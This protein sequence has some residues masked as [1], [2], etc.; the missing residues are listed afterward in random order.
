MGLLLSGTHVDGEN[1]T[2]QSAFYTDRIKTGQ[3]KPRI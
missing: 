2:P 1:N 3:N